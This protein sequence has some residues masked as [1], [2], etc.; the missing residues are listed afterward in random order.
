VTSKTF[1]ARLVAHINAHL[2][3]PGSPDTNE[4]TE[5]F[6]TG[7]LN[8][9]RLLDLLAFLEAHLGR[10]IDDDEIRLDRFATPRRISE[11]FGQ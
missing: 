6:S 3:K 7:L 9:M 10:E 5:L 4:D 11:N 8:S 1:T 2:L